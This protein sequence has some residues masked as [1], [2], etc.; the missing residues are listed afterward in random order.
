[1]KHLWF[2]NVYRESPALGSGRPRPCKAFHVRG[3]LKN[4]HESLVGPGT[5]VTPGP[6]F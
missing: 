4:G 6:A 5:G 1:L 3:W 2:M